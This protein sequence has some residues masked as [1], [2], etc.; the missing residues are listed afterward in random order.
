MTYVPEFE[1][2]FYENDQN[3]EINRERNFIVKACVFS[4]Y[5]E[6]G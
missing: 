2:E 4:Q 1:D 3:G 5:R 6:S